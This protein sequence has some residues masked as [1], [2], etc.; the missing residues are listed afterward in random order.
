M[1]KRM[2]VNQISENVFE[3]SGSGLEEHDDA[4]AAAGEHVAAIY[5][6]GDYSSAKWTDSD[7]DSVTVTL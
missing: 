6:E 3:V 4:L 7:R 5:G 2:N 1:A